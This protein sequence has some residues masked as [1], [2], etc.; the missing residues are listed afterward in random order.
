LF[1]EKDF[2]GELRVGFLLASFFFEFG[3]EFAGGLL[4]G[5]LGGDADS[6][7]GF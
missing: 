5:F 1:V 4:G 7:A 3:E 2:V 6:T